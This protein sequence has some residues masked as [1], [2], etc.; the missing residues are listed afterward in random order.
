[1]RRL[2]RAIK[3]FPTLLEQAA[4]RQTEPFIWAP[5]PLMAGILAYFIWPVEPPFIPTLFACAAIGLAAYVAARRIMAGGGSRI[6]FYGAMAMM[7][8]AAGFGAGSLRTHIADTPQLAKPLGPVMVEGRVLDVSASKMRGARQTSKATLG[9]VTIE[10]LAPELTPRIVRLS[11]F[12]IP[13]DGSVKPGARIKVLARLMPPGGPAMP[14]GFNYRFQAFYEG[15]GAVGFT[16][17]KLEILSA[18]SHAGGVTLWFSQL[19]QKITG[20]INTHIGGDAGAVSAA[21]L[22]GERAGISDDAN[23]DLRDA[24]L[25]HLLSISGL[26]VAIVCGFVF[27]SVRLLLALSP[28]AA[29]H[30][31][32]KKIAAFAALAVGIFYTFLAGAPV[33]LQRSIM[34]TGI[35]LFAVLVDRVAISLRLVA[36]AALVILL[37][38]PE[39][40]LGASFQ[41]SFAA[42]LALVAFYEGWGRRLL[43]ASKDAGFLYK[44]WLYLAGVVATTVIA[45]MATAP[46]SIHQFGRFQV[47]GV[48]ANALAV[49]LTSFLVMPFGFL[50][51]LAMPLGLEKWFLIPVEWGVDG[52]LAVAQFIAALPGAV[53]DIPL[54]PHGWFLIAAIG[55][56]FICLIKGRFRII[57]VPL[58]VIGFAGGVLA[59]RP[60]MLLDA[61]G[62]IGIKGDAQLVFTAKSA[63]SF[64]RDNWTATWGISNEAPTRIVKTGNWASKDGKKTIACDAMACRVDVDG[65]RV[66]L[67]RNPVALSEECAW[68]QI[69]ITQLR[70]SAKKPCEGPQIID[71]LDFWLGGNIGL[72]R[73]H[74][75]G[76]NAVSSYTGLKRPWSPLNAAGVSGI[77]GKDRPERPAP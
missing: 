42:V 52:T 76:V 6:A 21:L 14:G 30:W 59:Q 33:P 1:M 4:E 39:M 5:L 51:L 16:L 11:G 7:L 2:A 58:M 53:I 32:I 19:R 57:G 22:S 12:H 10:R 40:M 13:A 43:T 64:T 61:D 70:R 60:V 37:Y 24:G 48:F 63:D 15:L 56:C 17:G 77:G 41:L 47:Y 50:S 66:S 67:I 26:H 27:F 68:A 74:H 45:S 18:S 62:G 65:V 8:V 44:A 36:L 75:G 20:I 49:P 23:D 34:M 35:V 72:Y 46:F 69:V 29:L 25:A 71:R 54:L 38:R 28:Y 3:A 73:D 31:P 55:F 9:D